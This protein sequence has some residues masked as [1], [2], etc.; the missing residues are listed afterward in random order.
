[1][2]A[3]NEVTEYEVAP[4]PVVWIVLHDPEPD[5][6][7]CWMMKPVSS[8]EL[9]CQARLICVLLVA[10]AVKLL[11]ARGAVVNVTD[12]PTDVPEQFTARTNKVVDV[13]AV[14]PETSPVFP[15]MPLAS[16]VCGSGEFRKIS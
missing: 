6:L 3:D 7:R 16:V 4:A 2:D 12:V 11:G 14:S 1:V 10:V 5:G 15:V 13:L 8:E 9:S